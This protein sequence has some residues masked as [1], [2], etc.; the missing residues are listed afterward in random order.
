MVIKKEI[1]DIKRQLDRMEDT[2]LIFREF[3]Y[4][5]L[6]R[7]TQPESKPD[8]PEPSSTSPIMKKK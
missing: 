2:V 1:G 4:E 3:I 8:R 6:P 5:N 7:K